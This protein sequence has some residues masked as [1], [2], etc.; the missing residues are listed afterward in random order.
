V[1]ERFPF[2]GV[3]G[4]S[5]VLAS[6]L[7]IPHF[8]IGFGGL[9][10]ASQVAAIRT[11]AVVIVTHV[12]L[13]L[14]FVMRSV[15]VS[16]RAIDPSVER[17]AASLGASPARVFWLVDIPLMAPGLFGGFLFAAIL[18]LTEFSASLFVTA[19]NTQTLPIAMFNYTRD[20]ADP[21]LAA[22]STILIVIVTI[23]LAVATRWLGLARVLSVQHGK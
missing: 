14:P 13:V 1:A 19:Q 18:S 15:Q 20:S 22:I 6:P 2:R 17:A 3:G 9:I 16:L 23:L 10:L 12:I 7:V 8:F 21:S 4:L 11:Y 5:I